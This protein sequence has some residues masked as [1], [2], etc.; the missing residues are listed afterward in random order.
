MRKFTTFLAITTAL[1]LV[2]GIAAKMRSN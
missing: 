2:A 1:G